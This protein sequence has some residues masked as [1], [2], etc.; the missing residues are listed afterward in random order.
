MTTQEQLV[1]R[2]RELGAALKDRQLSPRELEEALGRIDAVEEIVKSV[3]PTRK[4]TIKELRGLGKDIWR[5]V[6]VDAY[7]REERRSWR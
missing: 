2:L 4:S 3:P 6:D 7:I 5:S 1:Q